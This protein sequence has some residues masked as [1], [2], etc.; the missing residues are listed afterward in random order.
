MENG[1]SAAVLHSYMLT[2]DSVEVD[3]VTATFSVGG[4]SLV[5]DLPQTYNMGDSFDIEVGYHG[6]WTVTYSQTGFVYYPKN[7]NSNTLHALAYTLGEPWDA[8]RWMPCYDE[9][10]DKADDGCVISVTV[11]DTFTV[12]ANGE[13]I[14]V[15]AGPNNTKTFIWEEDYPVTT[16]LMHFGV[17]EYAQW[18]D[19]YY[20]SAGDTVEIRHFMWPEDSAFSHTSFQ[21]LPTAMFL[22]DSLYGSYPFDRYGQDVVYPY[23]WGGMEHQELSTIHRNWLLNQSERGMAHELAHMWWG[24]MVTCV[25]FRDIWLNEGYATYSDANYIWYRFGHTDF[26]NLMQSRAQTYFQEDASWRHPLYD[27]PLTELFNYGY[28]YCKASWVMHMLRYLDQGSYY[29]AIAA[30]RD[31]FEYGNA[32]TDDLNAVFSDAYGTDLTWFFDEWVYG[33]GY[34]Q[35][36]VYWQCEPVGSD[37]QTTIMIHQAQTNAPVFH[38]P[39]EI[40]L[41]VAGPDT[42]VTVPVYASPQSFVITLPDS[43]TSIS[44]D[45][46]TWLLKTC[47]VFVGIDDFA[48]QTP[49]SDFSFVANPTRSAGVTLSLTYPSSIEIVIFDVAGRI[50]RDKVVGILNAG[51]HQINLGQLRAGVYFCLLRTEQEEITKKLVVV[52]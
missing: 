27:P 13:L 48:Q 42:M 26:I 45:P 30:Y 51:I 50:V 6:S 38:M 21:Y 46:D 4:E 19:W 12:C 47:Q 41:N 32:S 44:V 20:S 34:P 40:L 14:S 37:Y 5:I 36:R 35:Y 31:S 18:S 25:D 22:F 52:D 39:V 24:D 49:V 9:P 33:Q 3:G 28:T 17:S 2:I 29:P 11:P 1:L 8:R 43:V 15:V 7:Y 10:Y 23:A 16:Y